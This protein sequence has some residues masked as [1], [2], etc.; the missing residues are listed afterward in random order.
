[1]FDRILK[2]YLIA[3]LSV[4]CMT[5]GFVVILA[6]T[7][8]QIPNI[9]TALLSNFLLYVLVNG[10]GAYVLVRPLRHMLG[11]RHRLNH[12]LRH[13]FKL[14]LR[15]ALLVGAIGL[16]YTVLVTAVNVLVVGKSLTSLSFV[17][18][19]LG[20]AGSHLVSATVYTYFA[21]DLAFFKV[22]TE[23]FEAGARCDGLR[24]SRFGYKLLF[25][26]VAVSVLPV[27]KL[28]SVS[29]HAGSA[30][31]FAEFFIEGYALVFLVVFLM[32]SIHTPTQ[33]LVGFS[34]MLEKGE[35]NRRAPTI[36]NDEFGALAAAFNDSARGL[37]K[38]E[39]IRETFGKLVSPK[40]ADQLIDSGGT[41]GGEQKRISIL[42]SDLRSFTTLAERLEPQELVA[43]LNRY[44]EHMAGPIQHHGGVIN[45]YIGDAILAVFGA[46]VEDPDH[47]RSAVHAGLDML[48][49]LE[50]F[51]RAV[52]DEHQLTMGIGIHTGDV[53]AGTIGTTDRMEYTVI[54]D[55]VNLAARLESLTKDLA[56][57]LIV[58]RQTVDAAG[59][60]PGVTFNS[61]G[62]T[63]VKGKHKAVEI[64]Q[65]VTQ[66]V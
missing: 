42:F 40:V 14:P 22:R 2:R 66:D 4:V 41:L 31:S 52:G 21:V 7:T 55:S 28:A 47:A 56:I 25:T 44:F 15:S 64:L 59:K 19:Q 17:T 34:R 8:D 62:T 58:S 9:L 6:L 39:K 60:I 53:I 49:A 65:P 13:S 36:S 45:K 37:E 18:A 23:L 51:N 33:A 63:T 24:Y 27:I 26:L 43:L 57:P 38:R 46:P 5:S 54:G 32:Y 3:Q 48:Q 20:M 30:A 29:V 11:D 1:M 35:F 10:V 12:A 16:A 50:E 61:L